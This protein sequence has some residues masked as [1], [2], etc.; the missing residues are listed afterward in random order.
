MRPETLEQLY[1]RGTPKNEVDGNFRGMSWEM[2]WALELRAQINAYLARLDPE[3]APL[4]DQAVWTPRDS[5]GKKSLPGSAPK[6]HRASKETTPE[7]EQDDPPQLQLEEGP[8]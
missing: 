5:Y 8:A 3:Q 7:P 1:P 6:R 4:K 2:W